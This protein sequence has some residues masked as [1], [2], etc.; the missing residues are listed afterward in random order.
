M[1]LSRK[2]SSL[3]RNK[4]LIIEG[5]AFLPLLLAPILSEHSGSSFNR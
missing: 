5:D 4:L 2:R 1:A 3:G